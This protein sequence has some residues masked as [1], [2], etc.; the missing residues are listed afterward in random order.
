[1]KRVLVVLALV[2]A[3]MAPTIAVFALPVT[4]QTR[5]SDCLY[6]ECQT[7]QLG[8]VVIVIPMQYQLNYFSKRG[9][10]PVNISSSTL[11]CRVYYGTNFANFYACRFQ[12]WETAEYQQPS[13]STYV[14]LNITTIYDT[15]YDF[16]TQDN[17]VQLKPRENTLEYVSIFLHAAALI[18]FFFWRKSE[19]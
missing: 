6:I 12:A 18:S 1:M 7:S 9:N 10:A 4:M 19:R 17:P 15:N 16:V 5:F 8:R 13:P 3:L 11:T 14:A 2:V